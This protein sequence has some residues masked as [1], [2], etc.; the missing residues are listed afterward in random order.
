M[1]AFIKYP[2]LCCLF[3]ILTVLTTTSPPQSHTVSSVFFFSPSILHFLGLIFSLFI[4]PLLSSQCSRRKSSSSVGVPPACIGS[5]L[6]HQPSALHQWRRCTSNGR[7]TE[8]Q[9]VRRWKGTWRNRTTQ[10]LLTTGTSLFPNYPATS[11]L[12]SHI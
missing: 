11:A 4:F 6:F 1:S 5:L 7:K 8:P 3:L 12:L 10:P 2:T 9:A